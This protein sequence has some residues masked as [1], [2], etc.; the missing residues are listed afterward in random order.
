MQSFYTIPCSKEVGDEL[1]M[2]KA[3]DTFPSC[4]VK[5][6]NDAKSKNI[7]CESRVVRDGSLR[8][9]PLPQFSLNTTAW[10]SF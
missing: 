9:T 3:K 1:G 5:N 10:A 2:G 8:N 6:T 7:C 4:G